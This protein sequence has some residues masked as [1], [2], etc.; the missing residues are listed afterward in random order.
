M[1][2]TDAIFTCE[3]TVKTAWQTGGVH[4]R[5]DVPAISRIYRIDQRS[6]TVHNPG[7]DGNKLAG[8]PH[9][10]R[11][12]VMLIGIPR[13]IK[14]HKYRVAVTPAG[15]R[16]LVDARRRVRVQAAHPRIAGPGNGAIL[17]LDLDIPVDRQIV[18]FSAK[19]SRP[20]LNWQ[21]D[22]QVVHPDVNGGLDWQPVHGAHT[23]LLLDARDQP[24]D[25]TRLV[26][27]RNKEWLFSGCGVV[28][29]GW[30]GRIIFK[31]MRPHLRRPSAQAIDQIIFRRV[32]TSISEPRRRGT[33]WNKGNQAISAGDNSTNVIAGHDVNVI[34]NMASPSKKL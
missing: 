6:P 33:L 5:N 1:T 12:L 22:H 29:V 10:T 30:L 21:V 3:P 27:V 24:L 11:D 2:G 19:P 9:Y 28:L 23:I 4:V 18:Y 17:A 15:V 16:Q 8:L 7:S 32:E 14:K 25:E 31:S 13:E 20:D 34:L 26:V